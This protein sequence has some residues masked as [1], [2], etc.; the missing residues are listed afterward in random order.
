MPL[1]HQ[2]SISMDIL[3]K[4]VIYDTASPDAS[5]KIFNVS[6]DELVF[7]ANCPVYVAAEGQH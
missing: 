5:K 3:K 1:P 4:E 7:A 6:E 2:L